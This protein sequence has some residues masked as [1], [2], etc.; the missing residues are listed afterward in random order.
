MEQGNLKLRIDLEKEKGKVAS[1]GKAASEA[2]ATQQMVETKLAEQTE[3]TAIAERTLLEV[4]EKV[5]QRPLPL[6][7]ETVLI[8]VLKQVRTKLV[9]AINCVAGDSDGLAV[10]D[11]IEEILIAS[12]WRSGGIGQ[13]TFMRNPV[14]LSLIAG[15]NADISAG[16]LQRAFGLAG[17]PLKEVEDDSVKG[18]DVEIMV[19]SRP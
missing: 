19:G 2:E 1:L 3:R 11:Q 5:K 17:L 6:D 16:F 12:G 9:V 18:P 10:A 14:G 7:R 8:N 4:Q 13:E 15:K